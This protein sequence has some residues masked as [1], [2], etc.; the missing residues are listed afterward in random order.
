MLLRLLAEE[1]VKQIKAATWSDWLPAS[2]AIAETHMG[3]CPQ[4]SLAWHWSTG[5]SPARG[6]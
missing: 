3:H 2:V 1:E 6:I 5:G 4:F